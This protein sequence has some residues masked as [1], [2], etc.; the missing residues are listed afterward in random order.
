MKNKYPVVLY[1]NQK[2]ALDILAMMEGGFSQIE[3]LTATQSTGEDRSSR[4]S[5]GIGFRNVFGLLGVSL[6]SDRSGVE[7]DNQA[8]ERKSEK[9][10]T[11]NSLFSKV[12]EQLHEALL[13]RTETFLDAGPGDFVEFN[14]VLEKNSLVHAIG[15][16]VTVM[17]SAVLFHDSPGGNKGKGGKPA[18]DPSRELLN[19]MEG[20]HEQVAGGT[21]A[22]LMGRIVGDEEVRVVVSLDR[23]FVGDES[24]SDLIDGE[25]TVLGKVTRVL[26]SHT[27]D[28]IDL[29]RKTSL[30]A[31]GGQALE[32]M[33]SSI[34]TMQESGMRIP[35][36]VTN[37]TGPALQVIPLAI[38]A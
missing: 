14:V 9:V 21:T 30:G 20:L 7:R 37:V 22:E 36:I 24:M 1:L 32:T 4:V 11:P 28:S 27:N 29:L 34:G 31:V 38:F 17:R 6:A 35:D 25:Y 5:G 23:A 18:R 12:R 8:I 10:H 3:T 15:T 19:Q 33:I 13:V 16:L 26:Q 2:Y